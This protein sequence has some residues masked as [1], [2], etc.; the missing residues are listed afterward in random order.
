MNMHRCACTF[1]NRLAAQAG[2]QWQTEQFVTHGNQRHFASERY[3]TFQQAR[4]TAQLGKRI[5]YISSGAYSFMAFSTL[6]LVVFI[7]R[8]S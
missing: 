8:G 4:H 7:R 1:P 3:K 5:H 6:D 2:Q